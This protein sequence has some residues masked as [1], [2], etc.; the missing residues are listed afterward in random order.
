MLNLN[1]DISGIP[2]EIMAEEK[3]PLQEWTFRKTWR[4]IIMYLFFIFLIGPGVYRILKPV[5]CKTPRTGP[6]VIALTTVYLNP[7]LLK[8]IIIS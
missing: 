8:N 5:H 6:G 4:R 2:E 7:D 3:L 1:D